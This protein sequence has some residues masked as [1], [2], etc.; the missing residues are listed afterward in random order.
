MPAPDLPLLIDAARRAGEIATSFTGPTAPRWDKPGDAGPVTAADLAVDKMLRETLGA[1]RPDYGWL[2]EES[3]D[4]PSRLDKEMVFV[5]DPIDGTRSFVEGGKTWAHSLAVTQSGRVTAAV[6]YLPLRDMLYAAAE[7]A[8]AT[9]NGAPV[10]CAP[11][12]ALSQ[13]NVLAARPAMNRTN[14]KE[15]PGFTRHYRPSLAYRLALVA[16]GKFDAMITLRRSWE[17]DIAAGALIVTEA[18]GAATTRR[19]APLIFNQADPRL[20]GVVAGSA[21]A[22]TQIVDTLA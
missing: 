9:L 16:E 2:S 18:G 19:G 17:W 6:V 22:V 14:W 5:V 3:E 10:R 4:D 13:T 12:T 8:G 1:A 21:K 7:G 20:D 15:Q 11:E